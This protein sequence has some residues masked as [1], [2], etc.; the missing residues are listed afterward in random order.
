MATIDDI[1][2]NLNM[3]DIQRLIAWD[4]ELREKEAVQ[5]EFGGEVDNGTSQKPLTGVLLPA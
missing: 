5:A 1:I 2:P 4:N 3:L